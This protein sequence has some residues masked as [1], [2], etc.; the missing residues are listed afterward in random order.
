M[1]DHLAS[2][3]FVTRYAAL[4]ARRRPLL[5][6]AVTHP[7]GTDANLPPPIIHGIYNGGLRRDQLLGDFATV[8]VTVGVGLR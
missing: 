5:L 7:Q 3:R 4:R 8:Q 2:P 1:K 6:P